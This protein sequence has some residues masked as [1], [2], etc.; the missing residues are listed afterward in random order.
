MWKASHLI[1]SVFS[2]K[3]VVKLVAGFWWVPKYKYGIA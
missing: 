3:V 1:A 2:V